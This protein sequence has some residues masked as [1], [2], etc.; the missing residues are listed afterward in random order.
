MHIGERSYGGDVC[1]RKGYPSVSDSLSSYLAAF[2]M[3]GA[4]FDE[5]FA[6]ELAMTHAREA[7]LRLLDRYPDAFLALGPLVPEAVRVAVSGPLEFEDVWSAP[8]GAA[9]ACLR[10]DP[11]Y[12]AGMV[13]R[14][15]AQWAARQSHPGG[16]KA[17]E[18][19]RVARNQCEI[20][21]R[22]K[23]FLRD[24]DSMREEALPCAEHAAIAALL[25][26]AF[27]I[28][29]RFAP[30][31]GPWT[32]RLL[33]DIVPLE[34]ESGCMRSG[35]SVAEPGSCHMSFRNSPVAIAEMLVHETTHQYYYLV[36]RFAPVDDGTDKQLYYSPAKQCGRPIAYILIAY[37]AFANVLLFSRQC[38]AAGYPDVQGHLRHNVEVL[39]KWIETFDEALRKTTALTECGRALWL[40]LDRALQRQNETPD[41][42]GTA[43]LATQPS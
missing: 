42:P 32:L 35:S 12:P 7:V 10:S 3:P 40:P 8:F 41:T 4:D 22:Y 36:T 27:D 6:R 11:A 9:W 43:T 2:A 23:E 39:S 19:M 38:L 21:I 33:R 29:D 30:Q 25:D 14:L 17:P 13:A 20:E 31:Y 1:A 28:I 34:S 15:L 24:D 16:D 5:S 37:H 26:E 18:G